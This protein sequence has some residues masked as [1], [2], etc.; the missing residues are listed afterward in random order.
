METHFIT[1]YLFC[2]QARITELHNRV[3]FS[4]YK[5]YN[6]FYVIKFI[7]EIAEPNICIQNT[8]YTPK[9]IYIFIYSD[10]KQLYCGNINFVGNQIYAFYYHVLVLV[11]PSSERKFK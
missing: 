2:L 11:L 6:G 8:F 5:I 1:I 3:T 9:T 10:K 4:K 7:F